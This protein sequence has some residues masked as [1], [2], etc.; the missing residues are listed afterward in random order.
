VVEEEE[1]KMRGQEGVM[2]TA[3]GVLK[4][5]PIQVLTMPTVV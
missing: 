4:W 1:C 3:C 2:P 5:S